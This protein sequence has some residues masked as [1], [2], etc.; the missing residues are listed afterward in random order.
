MRDNINR[1]EAEKSESFGELLSQLANN[2]A[3]LVR[4]EIALAKREMG[5][6]L[7]R[8]QSGALTTA[9]GAIVGLIGLMAL[10]AAAIAGLATI[11]GVGLSALIIGLA[12]GLIGAALAMKGIGQI[13]RTSLKPEETIKTLEEDK[14]WL[15]ELT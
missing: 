9:I 10:T 2:S 1:N 13:K 11:V 8:V 3:A 14:Q 7:E 5:E 15:K 6:K 12:L 4:D